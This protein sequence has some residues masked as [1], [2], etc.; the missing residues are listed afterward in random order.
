MFKNLVLGL[1][2][3]AGFWIIF[4]F[5][6]ALAWGL[7]VNELNTL[8]LVNSARLS[9]GLEAYRLDFALSQAA[10]TRAQDMIIQNYFDHFAPNGSSWYQV[11]P[12]GYSFAGENLA[13]GFNS[14]ETMLDA[15]L[16]SSS[17]RENILSRRFDRI[18]LA[19]I[20]GKIEGVNQIL[21]VQ[22]FGTIQPLSRLDQITIKLESWLRKIVF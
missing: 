6:P 2:L 1:T 14:A 12:P 15:W 3:V 17:H 10:L 20:Q 7:E 19:S 22:V 18:G 5:N 21:V 16:T 9:R 8:E 13:L 4:V 11:I